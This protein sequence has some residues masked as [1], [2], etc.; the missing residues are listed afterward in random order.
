MKNF[1][2]KIIICFVIM[3]GI[4][5]FFTYEKG[6]TNFGDNNSLKISTLAKNDD[7]ISLPSSGSTIG[8]N[9]NPSSGS[10]SN[11]GTTTVTCYAGTKKVG[12][13]CVT[14]SEGTYSSGV[15]STSCTPCEAGYFSY[16][17]AS[18]C[19]ACEVT[20]IR[21]QYGNKVITPGDTWC[22]VAVTNGGSQCSQDFSPAKCVTAPNT[23]CRATSTITATSGKSSKS[24]S[25]TVAP[26]WVSVGDGFYD[27][28][29][30]TNE[31]DADS[32]DSKMEYG[33]CEALP[34]E[35]D[36]RQV[37]R[38]T[39]VHK[40]GASCGSTPVK[41]YNFCCVNNKFIGVSDEVHW[42][43]YRLSPSCDTYYPGKGYTT[44]T[45][46]T[47][48]QCQPTGEEAMKK[49]AGNRINI[50]N[51]QE[52]AGVCETFGKDTVEVPVTEIKC[53]DND[54][55]KV[56][57]YNIK[58]DRLVKLVFDYGDDNVN[59]TNRV[60]YKGQ[61][62]KFGINVTSE[63]TCTGN[64]YKDD[65]KK[66]YKKF[67]D[68]VTAVEYG[69]TKY[70]TGGL[71]SF[72]DSYDEKNHQKSKD[73]YANYVNKYLYE[74]NANAKPSEKNK[75]KNAAS[76]AFA[77][78]NDYF[79]PLLASVRGYNSFTPSMEFDEKAVLSMTPK[80]NGVEET[81]ENSFEKKTIT[82]GEY[83]TIS[84]STVNLGTGFLTNPKN[85]KKSNVDNP[86]KIKL[87]PKLAYIT[88]ALGEVTA[89]KNKSINGGNKVYIDT[90][91]DAGTYPFT[92]EVSGV[93]NVNGDKNNDVTIV[94]DKCNI[95]I[96]DM[97][98]IYRPID[99]KNPFINSEWN[100]GENW[101]NS[102][103]NFINTIKANTWSNTAMKTVTITNDQIDEIKKDNASYTNDG[104]SPYLGICDR[105]SGTDNDI[106][107]KALKNL[108]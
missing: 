91:T 52:T 44:L 72:I 30:A 25:V 18:S 63:I 55:T 43:E 89:S 73:A 49:C 83:V 24:V 39:N 3:L 87:V 16:A 12:N 11:S 21:P 4:A 62:F 107:C 48:D 14:C 20:S 50:E 76:D 51:K 79:E 77:L 57:F 97:D 93:T 70:V 28:T 2:K 5:I 15:N 37:Y 7:E 19:T 6:N 80:I 35:P 84:S 92:I 42:E 31:K 96:N 29:M 108:K 75:F 23:K 56:S 102:K 47:K 41:T 13:S 68:K 85:Y 86:Y 58:C 61:G 59:N 8:S 104:N 66:V 101:T 71:L 40:R 78:W 45:N 33:S 32:I 82:T 65:W 10:N 94:D 34:K 105:L 54:K 98:I 81:F 17:G 60:L 100:K 26:P 99:I 69:Y 64:F 106:I 95:L 36:G 90:K 88:K 22:A 103:Y 38:C 74:A 9:S 67:R 1:N 46:V 53:T 27:H